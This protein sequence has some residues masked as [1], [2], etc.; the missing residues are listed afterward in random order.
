MWWRKQKNVSEEALLEAQEAHLQASVEHLQAKLLRRD[1][2]KQAD[3]L[4]VINRENHFSESLSRAMRK[5]G[6]V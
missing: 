4:R 3:E 5:G 6:A 1:A 2:K